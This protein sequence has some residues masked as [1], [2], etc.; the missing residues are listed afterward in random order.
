MKLFYFIYIF[1]WII[2]LVCFIK[3][4]YIFVWY[5][6]TNTMKSLDFKYCFIILGD[7]LNLFELFGMLV[8]LLYLII[9]KENYY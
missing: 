9:K 3:N 7:N 6:F 4:K 5:I 2:C 8:S 1:F